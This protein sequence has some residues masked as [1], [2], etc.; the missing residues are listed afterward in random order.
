[1]GKFERTDVLVVNSAVQVSS[2]VLHALRGS[3]VL[4][5][6][7]GYDHIDVDAARARSIQLARLAGVRRDAVVEMALAAAIQLLRRHPSQYACAAR[8]IWA[9]GRLPELKPRS[10]SNSTVA[11]VGLGV[12][13]CRMVECLLALGA[14]VLGVDPAGGPPG[15]EVVGLSEALR[16]ADVVSLH[17]CLNEGNRGML[18]PEELGIMKRE[19][20]LINTARGCLLDVRAAAERVR[21]GELRGL[22]IDVFP[23]EPYP[24]LEELAAVEGVLL[25][26]HAAGFTHDLGKRVAAGV[27]AAVTAWQGGRRPAYPL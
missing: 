21:R 24:A 20:V 25:T 1:M 6:T 11:V 8:G 12:I 10:L 3:H 7:S 2:Q 23:T 22:A 13:G 18:G 4:T 14:T 9:R 16:R 17:C 5:T 19:A 26:P 27:V 15:L